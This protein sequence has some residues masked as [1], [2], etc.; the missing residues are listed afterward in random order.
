MQYSLHRKE[1]GDAAVGCELYILRSVGTTEISGCKCQ[2]GRKPE[3]KKLDA[4]LD[5]HVEE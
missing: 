2:M 5:M 4:V 1:A 3:N